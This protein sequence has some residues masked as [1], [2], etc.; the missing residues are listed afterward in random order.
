MPTENT[1]RTPF[2]HGVRVLD[3][4]GALAG[5]YCTM[6]LSDLGA[7]VIKVEPVNGDGMRRR[8]MGEDAN[9][10]PFA[11]THRDKG[12]LA[13]DLKS[14]E[15]RDIV[16]R[17]AATSD[18][19]VEN[20]RTGAMSALGLGYEDLR[21]DCPDLVYCSISGFG[22]FGPMRDA[23]AV[24]LIAQA[25]GGMMSV[26]GSD[27]GTLAKAGYP[28]S[29]LGCGMWAAIGVLGA[30]LRRRAGGGG[31]YVDVSLSDTVASWSV[32]EVAD[33]I[34]TGQVPGPLGTA[35]RLA[36]PYQAFD[37][38]DG[39]SLVIGA[40]ERQWPG[41]CRA[42][43]LDLAADERFATEY[44]RFRN[45]HALAEILTER[46]ARAGRDE[47]IGILRA[48][49]IAC[50]PVNSIDAVV[51]DP[52]FGARGMFLRDRERHD[53]DMIVNTPVIADGAPRA[54]G[55]APRLGESTATLLSGL[56]FDDDEIR[57][58]VTKSVV[59]VDEPVGRPNTVATQS[60]ATDSEGAC[61][62][63]VHVDVENG[64]GWVVI[65]NPQRRNALSVHM[66]EAIHAALE[67]FDNDPEVSV[68][69]LRGAG[70]TAFASGV[71]ISEFEEQQASPAAGQRFDA[72]AA[73]VFE[74]LRTM[75][76]PSIAMISG[77]CLGGGLAV[78]LG[79]DLR[80]AARG[81]SFAIP[82]AK[83]GVGYPL[84]NTEALVHTVGPAFASEM[85]FT[86]R[87]FTD[88]EAVAAG[89][90]NRLESSAELEDAV[91][92]LAGALAANAPLSIRAAKAS[93]RA[94]THP[95]DT[96]LA[97]AARESIKRCESS[98]DIR[99]GQRAFMQKRPP[100]FVGR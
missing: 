48:N 88:E 38:G 98:D 74:S 84:P 91:R 61:P 72:A 49:G 42:L 33:Y 56:G 22:Q 67:K 58:L 96:E 52:Q 8:T 24:D 23:K 44:E 16:R 15:G 50:G 85:L 93:I 45:R 69:V 31:G 55:R 17:L 34:A 53:Q 39:E 7:E 90:V 68:V 66:M 80:I 20:F 1:A 29:D 81:S 43:D 89:L 41:L 76:T 77:Y 60:K 83:L 82:A 78:A 40:V 62:G 18:V 13:V 99:E 71:D 30:L 95:G 3:V 5:P 25:Y 94:V 37:C 54:R 73:S 10:L 26:T 65:D 100:R 4:T 97:L 79:A 57:R 36:A 46:F 59:T 6:I 32:W 27:D 87:R 21:E 92:A 14:E 19:L 35:H 28:V 75:S 2:L 47:W 9:P 63:V 64:I 86:G 51:A 70:E 11:L 12:S